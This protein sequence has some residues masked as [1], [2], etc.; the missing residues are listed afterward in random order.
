MMLWAKKLDL[1]KEIK[2]KLWEYFKRKNKKKEDDLILKLKNQFNTYD[3]GYVDW[4]TFVVL[5]KY[6][7]DVT[8]D[9]RIVKIKPPYIVVDKQKYPEA[10]NYVKSKFENLKENDI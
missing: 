5:W 1:P 10:Y 9:D 6:N 3:Y 2:K 7:I 8:K 4:R